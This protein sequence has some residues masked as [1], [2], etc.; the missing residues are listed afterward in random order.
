[1]S[2]AVAHSGGHLLAKHLQSVA[3]MAADFS[4]AFE[5]GFATQ[6]G[7]YLARQPHDLKKC[8][9]GFRNLV[10]LAGKTWAGHVQ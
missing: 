1:M 3:D 10:E 4:A 9:Y 6:G 5:P 2:D 8:R 7:A